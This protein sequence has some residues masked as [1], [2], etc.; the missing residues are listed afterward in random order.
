MFQVFPVPAFQDN[1]IWCI[2]QGNRV[3]LVDPGDAGPVLHML[4][5]EGLIPSAILIT[6]HHDDHVGGI[7]GLLERYP[8]PVYGPAKERIP[9]M[10]HPLREGDAV[11]LET[12]LS[13]KVL[14]VPGH[15]LGHIAYAGGRLLF[16]GDTLFT[17]GCGRLFEGTPEQMYASLRKLSL[18]PNDTLVYCAHEYT[19]DNLRFALKVEPENLELQNRF[20]ETLYLREQGLPTVPASLRLEKCTNPFLRCERPSVVKA[21]QRFAGKPVAPGVETFAVIRHWKDLQD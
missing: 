5:R 6:H 10:S 9:G 15:T 17:G 21:A 4:D 18:L 12:A 2:R 3:S 11:S 16:C 14:E 1:Y 8:L 13:L 19:L 7:E 20:K